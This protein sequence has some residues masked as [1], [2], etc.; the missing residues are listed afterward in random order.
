V[1]KHDKALQSVL[2]VLKRYKAFLS[3]FK[4]KNGEKRYKYVEN[5]EKRFVKPC[6]A[7]LKNA[8]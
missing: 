2:I 3:V 8:L 6:H 5:A 7:L 1:T 4:L